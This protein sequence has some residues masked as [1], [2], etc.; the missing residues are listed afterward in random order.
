[1][2]TRVGLWIDHR[3]AIVVCLTDEG[4]ETALI[5]SRVEKQ[6]RRRGDGSLA[7]A[8]TDRRPP[9][10]DSRQRALTGHLNG[11]YDAVIA[12]IRSA[13]AILV[14]GPGEAKG[15]LATRL[16]DAGLSA[17]VVGVEPADRMTRPQIAAKVRRFF[18]ERGGA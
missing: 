8:D 6:L 13:A 3:Q 9:A 7:P 4:E 1:M 14:F 16:E 10:D 5:V 15:Q 11:Y 2:R 17:L 12:S 18:R